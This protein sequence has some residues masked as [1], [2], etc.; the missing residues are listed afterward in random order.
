MNTKQSRRALLAGA[1]VVAAA[2]LAAGTTVTGF[3]AG[4]ATPSSSDPIFAA[5]ERLRG[6]LER[7]DTARAHFETMDELYP[8]Q[9]EPEPD[10]F[11]DWSVAQRMVWR[12]A[13]MTRRK[14]TPRD[15]A[16][17]RMS[18]QYDEVDRLS[19]ALVATAP[20]T[21]GGVAFVLEYWAELM[22]HDGD[23]GDFNFLDLDCGSRFLAGVAA[24]LRN[25][26]ARG[27]A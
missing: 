13:E 16:W 2:A 25:I 10:G 3:A 17:Q 1:P 20:T 18:D 11:D 21:I 15:S 24:A 6:A 19:D 4:L 9:D 27:Q 7:Y 8:S 12:S 26:V 5:A 14:E 22:A 23:S